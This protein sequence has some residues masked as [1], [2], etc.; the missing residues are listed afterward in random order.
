MSTGQGVI[1][2]CAGL[3]MVTPRR[4]SCLHQPDGTLRAGFI[5]TDLSRP[6]ERVVAF[7]T[8]AGRASGGSGKARTL[9]IGRGCHAARLPPK[10]CGFSF[11][12]WPIVSPTSC[13]RRLCRKRLRETPDGQA[14]KGNRWEGCVQMPTKMTSS[15]LRTP[16]GPSDA[17]V[18]VRTSLLSC[19]RA[20]NPQAFGPV[21]ESSGES[22]TNTVLTS[23]G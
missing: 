9:A 12:R 14:L 8:S 17:T 10:P 6:A 22:R 13:G 19:Q 4:I 7:T 2:R 11:I 21:W 1:R 20:T 18:V 16:F 23:A 15:A 3:S 5:V